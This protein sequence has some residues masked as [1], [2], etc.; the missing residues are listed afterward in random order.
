MKTNMTFAGA[1]M[2]MACLMASGCASSASK[3]KPGFGKYA[4]E[5]GE[6]TAHEKVS[7]DKA[8]ASALLAFKDLNFPVESESK[9]VQLATINANAAGKSVSVKLERISNY[10]TIVRIQAGP[11]GDQALSDSILRAMRSH[12]G[13]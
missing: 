2:L 7:F 5:Q 6:V 11:S 13:K 3:P 4:Y 1:L 10:S 12:Y 9:E 8:C